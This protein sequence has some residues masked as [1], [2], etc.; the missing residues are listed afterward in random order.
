MYV[1][2]Q[3]LSVVPE[4][5]EKA[6]IN[7]LLFHDAPNA[8]VFCSRREAVNKLTARLNNRGFSVVALSG[9]LSQKER[10]NALM[11][12][13]DGRAR[14]CVATDVA[15]RGLDLPGLDLVIHADLPRDREALLHRSGRTGRAGRKGL[16]AL[17]V[18]FRARRR[19]E[20]LLQDAGVDATWTTPP[21]PLDVE[22]VL[23]DR[24]VQNEM[25]SAAVSDEE[26]GLVTQLE[27][28]FSAEQLAAA[29]VRMSRAKSTAPEDLQSVPEKQER[30]RD[31][32]DRGP[33][34]RDGE[35]QPRG[36]VRPDFENGEWVR[37]GVGRKNNADPKWLVPMLCKAGGFHRR[38][39]GVI[40]ITHGATHVEL[41][42]DAVAMLLEQA[43]PDQ[44]IDKSLYVERVDGPSTQSDERPPRD[45]GQRDR[46]PRDRKP[47]SRPRRN[48]NRSEDGPPPKKRTGPKKPRGP[49]GEKKRVKKPVQ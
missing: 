4:D 46:P 31:R 12:M 14:V 22:G 18:P 7:L 29:V 11:A 23:N 43:G 3:A 21:G 24:L 5:V 13:R 36:Q 49:N 38:S 39:I 19:T 28:T 47:Q 35:R 37:L 30:S 34:E 20:R 33:R 32:N 2:Y 16:C 17:I 6:I 42:P 26:I 10:N 27:A 9:E 44:I 48:E 1:E 45:R 40:Q 41:T 8:I 25:F 15:A